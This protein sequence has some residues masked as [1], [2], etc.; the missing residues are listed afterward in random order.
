[1]PRVQAN[2]PLAGVN[3]H[4]AA[5]FAAYRRGQMPEASREY[6]QA[7]QDE[8]DNRDALLGAA[9][10][11]RNQGRSDEA[12]RHYRK[13]LELQPQDI[14]AAAGLAAVRAGSGEAAESGLRPLAERGPDQAVPQ[15]ELANL[16]ARQGRWTEAQAAYFRAHVADPANPDIAYNLAVSLERLEQRGPAADYYRRALALAQKQPARFDPA[17]AQ[18]RLA[19]LSG[20]P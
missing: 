16:Y 3:P 2:H 8:P 11:A 18:A 20:A 14:E 4:V 9:A 12:A 6:Q 19:A 15:V 7:L 1:M 5:G 10:V 13:L 17:V